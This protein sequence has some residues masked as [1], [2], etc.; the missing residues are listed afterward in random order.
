[1][2]TTARWGAGVGMAL[3]LTGCMSARQAPM[4]PAVPDP[5]L[6]VGGTCNADAARFLLGKTVDERIA[7]TARVRSGARLARVLRPGVPA[8]DERRDSRLDL[9]VD[10]LGQV[11]AVRCG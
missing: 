3:C 4:L 9:E 10:S 2:K 8:D 7:E 11:I 6:D 5:S 1:M